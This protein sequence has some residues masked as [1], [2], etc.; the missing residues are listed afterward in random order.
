MEKISI[1]KAKNAKSGLME[2][3][4]EC[5]K[6]SLFC[7]HKLAEIGCYV[8]DSTEIFANSFF[9]VYTIDP[10][11]N[12]YDDSDASSYR[13]D[14]NIIEQ[15][16]DSTMKQFENVHK[17]KMTGD[18]ACKLFEDESLA[19]VYI[20]AVHQYEDVKKDILNWLPKVKTGGIIAGHDFQ[21]A[22]PGTMEA[23]REVLGEPEILGKDT[24]WGFVKR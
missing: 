4:D 14:M 23:V 8:G 21:E 17:M 20:D 5:Q 22:F 10:W 6:S 9:E 18:E 24:S 16:F 1:R 11:L 13:Y 7:L 3:I 12:G 15:Q 2:F 19:M